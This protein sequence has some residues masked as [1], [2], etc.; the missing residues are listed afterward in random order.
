MCLGDCNGHIGRHID[1]GYGVGQRKLEGKLLLEFCLRKV[2]CVS[3][4]WFRR[5]G[6]RGREREGSRKVIFRMGE[7]ETKTDFVMIKKEHQRFLQ[8]VKEIP[9]VFQHA[10]LVADVG[11]REIRNVVRQRRKIVRSGKILRKIN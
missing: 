10:L 1:R 7:N 11:K 2:L 8:N 6:S 5:E 3:D 9:G 4:T